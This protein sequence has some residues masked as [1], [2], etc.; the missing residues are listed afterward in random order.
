M[1]LFSFF[2]ASI[3]NLIPAAMCFLLITCT[4]GKEEFCTPLYEFNLIGEHYQIICG[5]G[6][7][8]ISTYNLDETEPESS[9]PLLLGSKDSEIRSVRLTLKETKEFSVYYHPN[10]TL[11]GLW[12]DLSPEKYDSLY[13]VR[14]P[15]FIGDRYE[16]IFSNGKTG[17]INVQDGEG[18]DQCEYTDV[19]WI[20]Y[21]EYSRYVENGSNYLDVF[22]AHLNSNVNPINECYNSICGPSFPCE[23]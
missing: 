3:M 20:V 12:D 18:G 22:I 8:L 11:E 9:F 23:P 1:K 21:Y 17:Y 5:L 6:G 2:R 14:H 13:S 16:L 7:R 15:D 19:P 10:V 4:E